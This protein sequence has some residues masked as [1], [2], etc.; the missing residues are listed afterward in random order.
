M[1]WAG[2]DPA[3]GSGLGS[4]GIVAYDL[5]VRE[6]DGPWT[7]W[8][9]ATTQTEAPFTGEVRHTYTFRVRAR[10][11]VGHTSN[12]V[13]TTVEVAA[14]TKYYTLDGRRVAIRRG[15]VVYYLHGDHLGSTSLTTDQAGGVIAQARYLPYGEERWTTGEAQ[16]DFTFTGQRNDSYIKLIEMGARW[17]DPQLGRWTNPDTIIPDPANPQSLNRY[18][19]VFGNPVKFSDP[20]GHCPFCVAMSIGM[21]VTGNVLRTQIG[22][23]SDATVTSISFKKGAR[24]F[25]V[26]PIKYES[27]DLV[28]NES[29]QIQLFVTKDKGYYTDGLVENTL[30]DDETTLSAIENNFEG[31]VP[32]FSWLPQ[33]ASMLM[34]EASFSISKGNANGWYIGKDTTQFEG[35]SGNFD[36]GYSIGPIGAAGSF[37]YGIDE[38]GRANDVRVGKFELALGQGVPEMPLSAGYYLTDSKRVSPKIDL[39]DF[40]RPVCQAVGQCGN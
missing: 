5:Q 39:P 29:V 37:S 35:M 2:D 27:L 12:W 8:F 20:T 18:S 9:T 14:V 11:R 1:T 36:L 13:A 23:T 32:P 31:E 4:S 24:F 33:D 6:D 17:Y 30:Y 10:D 34:P 22:A 21:W 19:Y 3:V 25:G 38:Y 40:L 15:D 16:T 26:G 28:T 7:G